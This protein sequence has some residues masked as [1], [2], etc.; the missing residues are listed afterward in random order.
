MQFLLGGIEM[1]D[2]Q[3]VT[4]SRSTVGCYGCALHSCYYPEVAQCPV[5]AIIGHWIRGARAQPRLP[6]GF[7]S[8]FPC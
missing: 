7:S 8:A 5:T 6:V 1:G 3:N 4:A 2:R